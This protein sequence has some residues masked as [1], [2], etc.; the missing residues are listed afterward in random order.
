MLLFILTYIE[1]KRLDDKHTF[2]ILLPQQDFQ[3]T[4]QGL[5]LHLAKPDKNTVHRVVG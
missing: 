4:L 5:S 2:L 3:E 1:N